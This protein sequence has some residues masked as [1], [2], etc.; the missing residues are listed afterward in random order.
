MN[1]AN[2]VGHVMGYNKQLYV[3]NLVNLPKLELLEHAEKYAILAYFYK[4]KNGYDWGHCGI[5]IDEPILQENSIMLKILHL[6]NLAKEALSVETFTISENK[7]IRPNLIQE[8]YK[9]MFLK[10]K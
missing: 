10:C 7:I 6:S 8:S 9:I 2:F 4:Q 3:Y 5:I 1:C